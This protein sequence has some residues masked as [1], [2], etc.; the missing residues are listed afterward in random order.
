MKIFYSIL[1]NDS[2]RNTKPSRN[3]AH[4]KDTIT[5]SQQTVS[6]VQ[7]TWQRSHYQTAMSCLQDKKKYTSCYNPKEEIYISNMTSTCWR[8]VFYHSKSA[9]NHVL[10]L[11]VMDFPPFLHLL[12]MFPFNPTCVSQEHIFIRIYFPW[13]GGA[14]V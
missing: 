11:F 12:R 2:E 4:T 8:H 5:L 3:I 13:L 1:M 14:R 6:P 9:P 10:V 7:S